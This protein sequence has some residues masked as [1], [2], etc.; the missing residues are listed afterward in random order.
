MGHYFGSSVSVLADET[1]DSSHNQQS[2]RIVINNIIFGGVTRVIANSGQTRRTGQP[3]A[4]P[5]RV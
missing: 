1:T 5:V 2:S 4:H 3:K